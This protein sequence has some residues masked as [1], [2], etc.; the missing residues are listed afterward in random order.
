ML[1]L[2]VDAGDYGDAGGALMSGTIKI[3]GKEYKTV[4][5]RVGE[6]RDNYKNHR[7]VTELV[8]VSDDAVICKAMIY[9]ADDRLIAT[10]YAEEY[11]A[12]SKI[13]KTSA[14]ENC[15]T[16]AVGRA[17]AF[18]DKALMGSE[19][20]SADELAGAI[21][22]QKADEASSYLEDHN[23]VVRECFSSIAYIKD[24]IA[25]DDVMM[26]V[27]AWTELT[28]DQKRALWVAPTKGGVF[29]TEE[30]SYLKS[31]EFNAARKEMN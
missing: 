4:A 3:H 28:D 20:A 13:N 16:S 9:D 29:T 22:Q 21:T 10:G 17:L 23:K 19:I 5:L 11:R 15:E 27:E 7:L 14:V 6:F 8:S 31:D 2:Y 18:T 24:G 1:R 12:A 25:Q 26:V 30:R